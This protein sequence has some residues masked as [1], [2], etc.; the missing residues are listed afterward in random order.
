[1]GLS[2]LGSANLVR[3]GLRPNGPSN[4]A[5]RH[6][7]QRPRATGPCNPSQVAGAQLSSLAKKRRYNV[8][9][10]RPC[11]GVLMCSLNARSELQ[12]SITGWGGTRQAI[13]APTELAAMFLQGW[14]AR[15]RVHQRCV[16]RHSEQ[17]RAAL[18]GWHRCPTFRSTIGRNGTSFCA[19]RP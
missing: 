16:S 17:T 7:L 10:L 19:K 8:R 14:L 6:R 13:N 4:T 12:P 1:M 18:R 15:R 2:P 5:S 3:F 11:S 9:W